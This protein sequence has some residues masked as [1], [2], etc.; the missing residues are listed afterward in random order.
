MRASNPNMKIIVAKIIPMDPRSCT[1]C[2]PG[3][4]ALDAAIPAW[5]AGL[6]TAQSPIVVVDQWTGF[7]AATDTR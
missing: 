7:N 1:T 3:V 6:T 5:A 2:A 4:V